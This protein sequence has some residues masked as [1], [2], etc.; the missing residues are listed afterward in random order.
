M[1]LLDGYS[2]NVG[3][4]VVLEKCKII[5]LKS[6]DCHVLMQQLLLVALKGLLPKGPRIAIFQLCLFFNKLCQ[7]TID[8]EDMLVI[9]DDIA[10]TLSMLERFFLPTLFD[11]MMHL[12]IHLGREA[13]LGRPVQYRWMYP[14][15]R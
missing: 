15:D 1:K 13:R 2:S 8:R 9:K 4:C 14:F 12:P 6:H 10:E 5:G 3:N 7:R 11:I